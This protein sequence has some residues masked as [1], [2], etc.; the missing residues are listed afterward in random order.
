[1]FLFSLLLLNE[2]VKTKQ[3]DL[4]LRVALEHLNG[5]NVRQRSR[6]V[7]KKIINKAFSKFCLPI[8]AALDIFIKER[9]NTLNLAW[10]SLLSFFYAKGVFSV[11]LSGEVPYQPLSNPL[12]LIIFYTNFH[13]PAY[14]NPLFIRDLRVPTF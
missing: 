7:K 4:Y 9:N 11:K 10:I 12:P 8:T 3:N 2:L 6:K 13:P 14:Q 5:K 1:M